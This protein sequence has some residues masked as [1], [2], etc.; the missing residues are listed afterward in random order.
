[1]RWTSG[2][3]VMF[4]REVL[5]HE[6]WKQKYG[7]Q[8]R[9]KVWEK[10]AESLNGLNTV[11]ELYFKVT[12]R[13]VRDRYKLLVDNFKKREREEAAASGISPEETESDIALADIIERFEEADEMHKKQT[14]E[15]K[16]KNEADTHKAAEMRRRSLE[17]FS[18]SNARLGNEPVVKKSRNTGSETVQY[19]R[20]KSENELKLR[21]EELNQRKLEFKASKAQVNLNQQNQQLMLQNFSQL[22]QQQQQQQAALLVLLSK[23][24][25]Q[26]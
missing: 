23:L 16:S 22:L 2:H 7:S 15:K 6:P 18:E 14:D 13:S 3:D 5:V 20:E 24:A 9:G 21:T 4:L 25:D 17:T 26:K 12:Q 8:E 11:C 10:I 19:L 1:M